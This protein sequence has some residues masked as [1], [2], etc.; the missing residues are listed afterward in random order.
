MCFFAH[1]QVRSTCYLPIDGETN[2]MLDSSTDT[3][4]TI[5][6]LEP[7]TYCCVT[8]TAV[9]NC[10]IDGSPASVL[11]LEYVQCEQTNDIAPGVVRNL[12]VTALSPTSLLAVWNPPENYERPGVAYTVSYT[13]S[14]N[15]I[16][17]TSSV[18]D[19]TSYFIDNLMSNTEYS[20]AVVAAS[21]VGSGSAAS[22]DQ[23]TAPSA[24]NPPTNPVLT[25]PDPSDLTRLNVTWEDATSAAFSV[26]SYTAVVRC[27]EF[28]AS[29]N[30]LGDAMTAEFTVD[31]PGTDFSWCTGQVQA[32]NSIGRSEFSELANVVI[33][34]RVPGLPRCFL[35]DDLGSAVNIS[36]TVTHPFSLSDLTVMYSIESDI[37][38]LTTESYQ[39]N[40]EN[41]TNGVIVLVTRNTLYDFQLWLC[42]TAGCGP[43]C[44]ELR[45]FTTSTV[46]Y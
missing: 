17:T 33:P 45:N 28:E 3:S 21:G 25:F 27:N 40:A 23:T 4:G 26:M 20:V 44:Q 2:A 22:V 43:P 6:G 29:M 34:S 8:V 13:S 30:V 41:G 11:G 7:L 10:D 12:T 36:F 18:L 39:F 16:P 5:T 46:S 31:D 32:V 19:Q 9:N 37:Q 15:N 35:T 38:P 14:G 42:N 1:T 24:P